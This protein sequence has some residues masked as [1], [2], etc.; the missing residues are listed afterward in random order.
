[1]AIEI[2]RGEPSAI[3]EGLVLLPN[4]DAVNTLAARLVEKRGAFTGPKTYTTYTLF[5]DLSADLFSGE[6]LSRK[7][8]SD[9]SALILLRRIASQIPE[10]ALGANLT[11]MLCQLWELIKA[12]GSAGIRTSRDLRKTDIYSGINGRIMGKLLD[13]YRKELESGGYIDQTDLCLEVLRQLEI[14]DIPEWLV[15][16]DRLSLLYFDKLNLLERRLLETLGQSLQIDIYLPNTDSYRFEENF[17]KSVIAPFSRLTQSAEFKGIRRTGKPE[18]NNSIVFGNWKLTG[19][20]IPE[21]SIRHWP[22]LTA[23]VANNPIKEIDLIAGAIRELVERSPVEYSEITII[24]DNTLWPKLS[25]GL[26]EHDIPFR[27]NQ[28]RNLSQTMLAELLRRIAA[29]IN[30]EFDREEVFR[31][32]AHELLFP[33]RIFPLDNIARELNISGGIPVKKQWLEKLVDYNTDESEELAEIITRL[34][35][36]FPEKLIDKEISAIDYVRMIQQFMDVFQIEEKL[37]EKI[38]AMRA[39]YVVMTAEASSWQAFQDILDS[40]T[41][42]P[43]GLFNTHLN[44]TLELMER[45][46]IS[47]CGGEGC[48]IADKSSMPWIENKVVIFPRFIQ[49]EVP[50]AGGNYL[51][52]DSRQTEKLGLE[53]NLAP[54][55]FII[56]LNNIYHRSEMMII[57]RSVKEGDRPIPES[58]LWPVANSDNPADSDYLSRMEEISTHIMN[59]DYCPRKSQIRSGKLLIGDVDDD[60]IDMEEIARIPG[61]AGAARRIDVLKNQRTGQFGE[62]DGIIDD[63]FT[64][65]LEEKLKAFRVTGLNQYRRCPFKYFMENILNIELPPEPGLEIEYS[66]RGLVLHRILELFWGRKIERVFSNK[67][68]G[69]RLRYLAENWDKTCLELTI[70]EDSYD[71]NYRE[72]INI[73][74]A[75]ITEEFPGR[76]GIYLDQL[77][78]SIETA[79]EKYLDYL[80]DYDDGYVPVFTEMRKEIQIDGNLLRSRFD[81]VD[82]NRSGHIRIVDYKSGNGPSLKDL[83]NKIELQLPAYCLMARDMGEIVAGIY[84][85]KFLKYEP[86]LS[87]RFEREDHHESCQENEKK[88]RSYHSVPENQWQQELE[89]YEH[90][91]GLLMQNIKQ[92]IF[93]PDPP[94]DKCTQGRYCPF[95]KFCG[96][97]SNRVEMNV[98]GGEE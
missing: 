11:G 60:S 40:V 76:A 87:V 39:D 92:G 75:V 48:I 89:Y 62:Y 2:V 50:P 1:M 3:P 84:W 42:V 13:S 6:M 31:L 44:F 54:Y 4:N 23:L 67:T 53:N 83:E 82:A 72:I 96:F 91:L 20:D 93:P 43:S 81:R 56:R 38:Q 97:D 55:E 51:F 25:S 57:T 98:D 94:D 86:K 5:R 46:S 45:S 12:L 30:G 61:I 8:I 71:R 65:I 47:A 17:E 77:A 59:R 90:F 19:K 24:S 78:N 22:K 41:D 18:S 26:R 69:E 70:D 34:I 28:G 21:S 14:G 68:L 27:S 58:P 63:R 29:M 64:H 80:K 7:Q 85:A 33:K 15:K 10:L 52:L 35:E 37:R 36:V 16:T 74:R 73:S 66:D 88:S 95:A 79:L 32:M 49:K 9:Q